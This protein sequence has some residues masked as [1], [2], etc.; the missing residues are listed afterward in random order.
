MGTCSVCRTHFLYICTVQRGHVEL[1][2]FFVSSGIRTSA[3]LT[4]PLRSLDKR[5]VPY[6]ILP[7]TYL[8]KGEGPPFT[9]LPTIQFEVS[10]SVVGKPPFE[11][12]YYGPM[13]QSSHH[14][15][16]LSPNSKVTGMSYQSRHVTYTIEKPCKNLLHG[17]KSK[18]FYKKHG[19]F[20]NP[21]KYLL[22]EG[23]FPNSFIKST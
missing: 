13:Q 1:I 11:Q 3:P 2:R 22:H 23:T 15:L 16:F 12:G 8:Q 20:R 10:Q 21:C 9:S 5:R 19:T 7:A 18:L 17:D 14:P 6:K 4:L